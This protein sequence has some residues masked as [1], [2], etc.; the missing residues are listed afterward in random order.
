MIIRSDAYPRSSD[1]AKHGGVGEFSVE[2]I[3]TRQQLGQAGRLFVR[4]TLKPG[5]S[6]G[7]HQHNG[8]MEI[9]YF[10]SGHGLIREE[11]GSEYD[12][13]PGD[14]GITP[15]GHAHEILNSSKTE[16]LVYLAIVIFP[17]E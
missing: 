8:D 7:M 17:G 13:Y 5:H 2:T 6:V 1:V 12:V 11:D 9:C 10:L 14:A 16:D 4:G 15:P 3:L